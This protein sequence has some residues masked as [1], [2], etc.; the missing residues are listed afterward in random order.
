MD[1]MAIG[2]YSNLVKTALGAENDN[3]KP[4]FSLS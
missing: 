2:F 3:V 1:G 4:T